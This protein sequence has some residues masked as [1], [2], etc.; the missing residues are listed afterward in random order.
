[1]KLPLEVFK[2]Y[3]ERVAMYRT[4]CRHERL[5]YWQFCVN[6]VLGEDKYYWKEK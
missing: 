1:M 4:G 6:A 5:E 2:Q 3:G